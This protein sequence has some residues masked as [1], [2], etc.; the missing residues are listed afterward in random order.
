MNNANAPFSFSAAFSTLQ[1]TGGSAFSPD[2]T[3]LYGAFNVAANSSPAPPANSS[4]LLISN[5]SNLAIRLGIRLPE[6]IVA[7]MV[8]T[9]D[10]TNAWSL[11]QSG[12]I[13][14]PLSTLYQYPILSVNSTQVFLTQ[15]PC[16]PGLA[17]ATVNVSNIGG[18]KLTYAVTTINSALTAQVSTGVAPSTITFTMEPGRLTM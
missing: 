15:N 11:S 13:Y 16:N 10:G 9:S 6:N 1:N 5:P 18:G 17:Q 3:T 14:L 12:L 2:G 7:K 8:M 4:T